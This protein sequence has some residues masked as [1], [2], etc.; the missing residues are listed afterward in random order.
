MSSF[1]LPSVSKQSPPVTAQT[2]IYNQQFQ[3]MV[4]AQR[5]KGLHSLISMFPANCQLGSANNLSTSSKA[6]LRAK[7]KCPPCLQQ[8]S[9]LLC[10]QY[11]PH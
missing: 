9:L 4:I 10:E 2:L 6:S 1:P 5:W 3:V 7:I 11:V 8:D